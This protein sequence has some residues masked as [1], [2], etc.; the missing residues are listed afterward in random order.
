MIHADRI[1]HY[2]RKV[3]RRPILFLVQTIKKYGLFQINAKKALKLRPDTKA[4]KT[5]ISFALFEYL[6]YVYLFS[7]LLPI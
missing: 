6:I 5:A 3:S 2:F 7:G 1:K 4:K